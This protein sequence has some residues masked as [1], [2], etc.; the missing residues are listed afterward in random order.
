MVQTTFVFLRAELLRGRMTPVEYRERARAL[1]EAL[2]ADSR[3]AE[4]IGRADE[5]RVL[6]SS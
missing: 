3:V 6:L 2:E 4:V 5:A 1:W